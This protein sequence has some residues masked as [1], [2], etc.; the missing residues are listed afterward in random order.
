MKN[1]SFTAAP[2]AEKKAGHF[3]ATNPDLTLKLWLNE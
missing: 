1:N 2:G 3:V